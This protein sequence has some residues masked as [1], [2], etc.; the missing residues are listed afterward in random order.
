MDKNTFLPQEIEQCTICLKASEG[1]QLRHILNRDISGLLPDFF[2]VFIYRDR[3]KFQ[4]IVP[5]F[6]NAG[7]EQIE[8]SFHSSSNSLMKQNSK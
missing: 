6:H 1:I 2:I 7:I 4:R 3:S 8:A 5:P